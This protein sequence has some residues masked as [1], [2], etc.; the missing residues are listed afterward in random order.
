MPQ[1]NQFLH[2][3]YP[4]SPVI[5]PVLKKVAVDDAQREDFSRLH[6]Q[7]GVKEVLLVHGT[8]MGDDPFGIAHILRKTAE[9]TRLPAIANGLQ[10]MARKIEERTRS[11]SQSLTRDVA[12][13]ND[14]VRNRFQ[15][16]V[17][18]DPPVRLLKPTWSSQNHHLAR[19]ELAVRLL[20][21]LASMN[22]TEYDRVLLWGHSHAGNGFALLSNLLANE[23]EAV[24]AFFAAAGNPTGDHWVRARQILADAP[25]PHPLAR[26]VLIAGFGTPV[27]YGWDTSGYRSLLHIQHHRNYDPADPFHTKPLFPM[28]P[29]ADT[30]AAK[31]GDWVQAFAIAGTDVPAPATIKINRQLSELLEANLAEPEYGLDTKF[32]A[33]KRVRD[34]C[35][36]WKTGTRCHTDGYNL[37]LEYEPSGRLFLGTQP[38]EEAV[39]GHGVATTVDWL[40][41]HLSLVM[42]WLDASLTSQGVQ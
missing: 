13:Y 32:I 36:R 14:E 20:C 5:P 3:Q 2:Q 21:Q 15:E 9:N 12:N 41:V 25:S 24:D 10:L 27:R 22:L 23:P 42:Q 7:F 6:R 11:F 17:G 35:V 31:Y 26:H 28:H 18:E 33:S 1:N 37:L 19:A 16:L 38:V 29:L 8:F 4:T 39:L 40:P 34:A 30:L